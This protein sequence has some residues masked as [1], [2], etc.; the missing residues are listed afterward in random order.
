MYALWQDLRY[1][2]RMLFKQPG[3]T[4]IAVI[5]MALGIGANTAIFSIIHSVLLKPLPYAQAERLVAVGAAS[6]AN[7]AE[8]DTISYPDYLDFRAQSQAF[9]RLAV[10]STRGFT[11]TASG[12]AVRLRGAMISADLFPALGISPL[13]GRTFLPAEDN[14]AGGRVAVLSYSLW[15]SRFNHDANVIGQDRKSVV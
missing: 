10:Y 9:E 11:L 1:G 3:F 4:L 15:Q 8:L 7:P 12:G 14:A 13:L 2:A 6:K 5:T